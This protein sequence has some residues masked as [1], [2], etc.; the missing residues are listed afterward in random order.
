[1]DSIVDCGRFQKYLSSDYD[2]DEDPEQ[3]CQ[4]DAFQ[5]QTISMGIDESNFRE[6]HV[7]CHEGSDMSGYARLQDM[8]K[9][10][11][12]D[13]SLCTVIYNSDDET[14]RAESH[15]VIVSRV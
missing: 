12:I 7:T 8:I 15:I 6:P 1:M 3:A 11:D 5:L 10:V 4:N 14:V 2:N 13:S 9:R